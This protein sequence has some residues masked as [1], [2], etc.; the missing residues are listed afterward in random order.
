MEKRGEK[1][2]YDGERVL[3]VSEGMQDND[4]DM[5]LHIAT[6]NGSACGPVRWFEAADTIRNLLARGKLKVGD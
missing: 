5:A 1:W 6:S 2:G 3:H 4:A